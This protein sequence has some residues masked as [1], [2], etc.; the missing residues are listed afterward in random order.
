MGAGDL[1]RSQGKT[2]RVLPAPDGSSRT[3]YCDRPKVPTWSER[4]SPRSSN[5]FRFIRLHTL[6]AAQKVKQLV[7][8]A[9]RT[10]Q[11]KIWGVGMGSG[12][13]LKCPAIRRVPFQAR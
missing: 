6:G 5:P 11:G 8:I 12:T 4:I 2:I 3:E 7:F 1:C 10:L 13:T 9:L